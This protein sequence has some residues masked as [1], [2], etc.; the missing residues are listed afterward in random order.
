MRRDRRGKNDNKKVQDKITM[1]SIIG[2][3]TL[4]VILV[5]LLIYS[6]SLKKCHKSGYCHVDWKR[7]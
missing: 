5:G 6:K 4:V 2:V 7:W 3:A 1:Y